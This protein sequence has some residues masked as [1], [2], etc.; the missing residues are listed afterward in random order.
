MLKNQS[1]KVR[2]SDFL[3]APA[4]PSAAMSTPNETNDPAVDP[5]EVVAIDEATILLVD[6]NVQ[7]LE[8]MQAYL[9]DLF[10]QGRDSD[11]RSGSDVGC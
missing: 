2:S 9:D 7:N 5:D 11:R 4:I 1:R 8:L 10:L 6:D 3:H